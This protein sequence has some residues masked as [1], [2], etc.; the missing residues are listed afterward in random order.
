MPSTLTLYD[1]TLSSNDSV[2]PNF[3]LP[4]D[5]NSRL[6]I[7]KFTDKVS[8]LLYGNPR[9]P[10]GLCSDQERST[11]ISFLTRDFEELEQSKGRKDSMH[12]LSV[13]TYGI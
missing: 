6:E 2:D 13:D 4:E 7:E 11:L 1:W 9:D 8:R 12:C 5:I 10:V 3:K